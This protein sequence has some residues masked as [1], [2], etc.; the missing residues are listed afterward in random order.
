[1]YYVFCSF[2]DVIKPLLSSGYFHEKAEG[3]NAL[4]VLWNIIKYIWEKA[5]EKVPLKVFY[6][7][8]QKCV[9][10]KSLTKEISFFY[11]FYPSLCYCFGNLLSAIG[12]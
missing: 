9:A 4:S 1:M 5:K 6:H 11:T 7:L 2:I 8:I 10:E 12:H 3:D